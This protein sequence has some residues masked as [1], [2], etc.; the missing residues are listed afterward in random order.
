MQ[1]QAIIS[2]N[3]GSLL[4]RRIVS[5]CE[6]AQEPLQSLHINYQCNEISIDIKDSKFVDHL[7]IDWP[8]A[9]RQYASKADVVGLP[10]RDEHTPITNPY[11][12]Q[13]IYRERWTMRNSINPHK[14][15]LHNHWNRRLVDRMTTD[16][17]VFSMKPLINKVVSLMPFPFH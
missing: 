13:W 4:N 1:H 2:T 6:L 15:P 10:Y 17:V 7:Y 5:S 16:L 11:N 14:G 8:V 12:S 3:G 9:K